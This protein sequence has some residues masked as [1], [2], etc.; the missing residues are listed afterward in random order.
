MSYKLQ[1]PE[2]RLIVNESADW[3][4]EDDINISPDNIEVNIVKISQKLMF[5]FLVSAHLDPRCNNP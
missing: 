1:W 4:K 2:Q 3:G 5:V